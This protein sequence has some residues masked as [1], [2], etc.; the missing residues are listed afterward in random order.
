VTLIKEREIMEISARDEDVP[1]QGL[2]TFLKNLLAKYPDIRETFPEKN[3]LL[4]FLIHDCLFHKETRGQ[5][6]Q[7]AKAMPPKCKHTTTRERCLELLGEVARENPE[8][9]QMLTRYLKTHI[10]ETFWR[11]PRKTDWQI[12]VHQQ[13]RSLTGF[14]GLKNI[15][16]ICYMN[17]IMQQ[18]FMIP[19]FR[20]AILEVEDTSQE[21][22]EE[23]VLHQL[24]TIFGGLMEIEKQYF[25]PK[26]F[27]F[28]FKDI[29]GSSLDPMV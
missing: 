21:P 19:T 26:R 2:F 16:C 25:N 10:S 9:V 13:E 11:T 24:K 3:S 23:N 27:C 14:V 20:K 7:K 6:I 1:L 12:T 4:Y 22:P 15:G 17:S 28:A 29:D 5:L 18:L 8:G